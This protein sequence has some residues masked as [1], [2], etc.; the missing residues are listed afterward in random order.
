M[1]WSYDEVALLKKYRICIIV[2]NN[3]HLF[4]N[5][6]LF[7]KDKPCANRYILR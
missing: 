5:I 3:I 6:L 2:N 4:T 1:L 7:T